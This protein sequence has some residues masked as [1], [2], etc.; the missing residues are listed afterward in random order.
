MGTRGWISA[1]SHVVETEQVWS[2]VPHRLRHQVPRLDVGDDGIA[3]WVIPGLDQRIDLGLARPRT[4]VDGAVPRASVDELLSGGHD[5]S[6]RLAD[7]DVDGVRV[8]I[9]YPTIGLTVHRSV[10]GAARRTTLGAY[11]EWLADFCAAAP[12]R[13]LGVAALAADDPA[14]CLADL[15]AALELSPASVLLPM[16]PGPQAPDYDDP[17]WS[18]VFE[19]LTDR[20]LPLAFHSIAG[21][22]RPWRGPR[23]A[24]FAL[25]FQEAQDLLGVLVLGG[26]L[27]RW[28]DLRVVVCESDGSWL[29]H[30]ADRFDRIVDGHGA[31]AGAVRSERTP[32]EI[33]RDQV[34]LSFADD[35]RALQP[36]GCVSDQ[37]VMWGSDYPHADTTWPESRQRIAARAAEL[38][39]VTNGALDRFT[40]GNALAVYGIDPAV[41]DIPESAAV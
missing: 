23:L 19:A 31:W 22:A 29:G 7:Q 37:V 16:R 18:P 5:P 33:V 3:S 39:G 25:L 9:L 34:C 11:N 40:S 6:A 38:D 35:L 27:E 10:D 17:A 12:D 41:L 26:V 32:T 2:D 36:G 24:S 1:D 15:R 28:P 21:P 14:D 20:R 13:L 8:E 30:L 4:G